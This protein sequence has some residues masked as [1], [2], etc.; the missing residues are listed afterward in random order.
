MTLPMTPHI[1]VSIH[2]RENGVEV[3][4]DF[5]LVISRCKGCLRRARYALLPVEEVILAFG[6]PPPTPVGAPLCKACTLSLPLLA[7]TT[8]A[9][10]P[11][12]TAREVESLWDMVRQ[13]DEKSRRMRRILQSLNA[14]E[15]GNVQ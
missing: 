12:L 14:R 6:A 8:R 11:V 2:R 4:R 3:I 7:E 5:S 9:T 10:W 13:A 1:Y 15:A